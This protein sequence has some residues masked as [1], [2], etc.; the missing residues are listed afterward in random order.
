MCSKHFILPKVLDAGTII[1]PILQMQKLRCRKISLWSRSQ[2][3]VPC[4]QAWAYVLCECTVCLRGM[5]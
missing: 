4:P 2:E 1:I 3:V 5:Q